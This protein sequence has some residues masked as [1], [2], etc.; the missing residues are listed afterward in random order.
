[1]VPVVLVVIL[2]IVVLM[3]RKKTKCC[4][5]RQVI[6]SAGSSSY[7][8]MKGAD[9]RS[10]VELEAS[11][12]AHVQDQ[13]MPDLV[14]NMWKSETSHPELDHMG[15]YMDVSGSDLVTPTWNRYSIHNMCGTGVEAM[16]KARS[17]PK[18]L[19]FTS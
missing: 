10:L 2:L 3:N 8:S 12:K 1:M 6:H 18:D 15:R 19:E 4:K 5:H 16:A 17:P 13:D 9:E 11:C 7:A 14:S